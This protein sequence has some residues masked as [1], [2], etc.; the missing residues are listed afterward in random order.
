MKKILLLSAIAFTT[1]IN[2]QPTI[3]SSNFPPAGTSMHF[4]QGNTAGVSEGS[5]GAA[6]SWNFSSVTPNGTTNDF[7]YVAAAGTPYISSF[8]GATMAATAD[9]GNGGLIYLYYTHNSSST[10]MNG[11]GFDD[12]GTPYTSVLS[13]PQIILNY[14]VNYNSTFTDV[15][16]GTT[17]VSNSGITITTY[18][19]GSMTFLA[20]GYGSLTTPGGTYPNC[21]RAKIRQVITDSS[22]YVGIPLP[23]QVTHSTTTTYDWISSGAND[24]L[25]QFY[26]SYDTISQSGP[27][28]ISK[29]VQ[30][31][32]TTAGINSFSPASFHVTGYP[33]PATDQLMLQLDQPLDG[34]AELSIYN[35]QGKLVKQLSTIMKN[36]N[37]FDWSFPVG[38]L[39]P[40]LYSAVVVCKDKKWQQKFVKQ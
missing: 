32:T 30:Y 14:P 18:R 19:S 11:Y 37:H 36:G 6:Q 38:E 12:M 5:G 40:G 13:D 24:H 9:D 1:I 21:L 4:I 33:N 35:I 39:N 27:P 31:Q 34:T 28:T 29:T 8:P 3:T 16:S 15:F 17:T 23:A 25:N 2:A 26:I 10:S 7:D 20:D 22:V